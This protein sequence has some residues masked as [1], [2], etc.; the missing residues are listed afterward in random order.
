MPRD[1]NPPPEP[2]GI[3][4]RFPALV[5][6]IG[7]A[8]AAFLVPEVQRWEGRE[9]VPYRDIVGIWTVCDGDT[10]GVVPGTAATEAEC[11]ARL[12]RQ[13]IAHAE[14][15]LKCVPS[16]KS[17][18]NALAASVSLAYNIGV[19]GFCGSTT[20]RRFRAGDWRSGCDAFLRWNRAGGREIRGLTNRR[21]SERVIC[22]RD[23]PPAAMA[24]PQAPNSS[25]YNSGPPPVR[26]QGDGAAVVAFVHPSRINETCGTDPMPK[27]YIRIACAGSKNGTPAI[28]LP[29]PCLFTNE[30]FALVACHELG[31]INRWPA[32]HGN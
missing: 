13:L 17:R 3:N 30:A 26:F 24:Q 14:P 22:L 31:H 12:E 9:L 7:L 29:N 18:P 21:K 16:L 20:A 19:S 25:L 32:S 4:P 8:A 1:S 10:K 23:A 15:V 5:G 2:K 27:P 6:V 11:D 28:V